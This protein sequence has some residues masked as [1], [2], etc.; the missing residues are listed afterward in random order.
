MLPV[1]AGRAGMGQIRFSP[2]C[3]RPR[4]PQHGPRLAARP[5]ASTINRPETTILEA[6][7]GMKRAAMGMAGGQQGVCMTTGYM[8]IGGML[9]AIEQLDQGGERIYRYSLV[10]LASAAHPGAQGDAIHFRIIGSGGSGCS[11]PGQFARVDIAEP[12][13]AKGSAIPEDQA[14]VDGIGIDFRG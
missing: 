12:E 8:A 10:S 3:R 2:T 13:I 4:Q 1:L 6:G 5:C 14:A 9:A 11:F 7:A